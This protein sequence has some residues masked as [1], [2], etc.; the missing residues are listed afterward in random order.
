L[1]QQNLNA[2]AF[3]K[4]GETK[5]LDDF[6]KILKFF[7]FSYKQMTQKE[8]NLNNLDEVTLSNK[9]C[10]F[11]ENNKGNFELGNYYFIREPAVNNDN[12]DTTKGFVD[13]SVIIPNPSKLSN[14]TNSY[15][16]ENKRLDGYSTKNEEYICNGI[17][18]RFV[19]GKYCSNMNIAGMIGFLQK[20]QKSQLPDIQKIINDINNKITIKYKK[21]LTEN[22]KS[23]VIQEDFECSYA[24]KHGRNNGLCEI[25][26]Y[27]LMFDVSFC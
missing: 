25:S 27:H 23:V 22:L 6:R 13:I 4:K 10:R 18:D 16:F 14:G 9:L 3:V 24:S 20:P 17:I 19:K 7:I 21:P 11:L 5:F 12:T 2:S 26:L 15:T 8:K 1:H